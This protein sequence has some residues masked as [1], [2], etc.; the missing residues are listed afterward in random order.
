MTII[1]HPNVK[2]LLAGSF[3]RTFSGV[4]VAANLALN[5]A[6]VGITVYSGAIP[7]PATISSIWVTYNSSASNYLIHFTGV[8]IS[9]IIFNNLLQMSNSPAAATAVNTGTASWA[10]IW[11]GQPSGAQLSSSSLP[12]SNFLVTSVSD[13]TGTGIVRFVSSS[14]VATTSYTISDVSMAFNA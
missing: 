7:T 11:C 12:F 4:G 9:Q 10:I 6:D 3:K 1:Y 13:I 5:Y 2:T 14:L 8:R